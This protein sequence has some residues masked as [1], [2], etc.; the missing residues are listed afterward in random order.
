MK[1]FT[2]GFLTCFVLVAVCVVVFLVVAGVFAAKGLRRWR[3]A[4]KNTTWCDIPNEYTEMGVHAKKRE[5]NFGPK[6]GLVCPD[7]R[8]SSL[9]EKLRYALDATERVVVAASGFH[10]VSFPPGAWN[11]KVYG[12]DND[13]CVAASFETP[14]AHWLVFRG[15]QTTYDLFGVDA[16][17]PQTS[18]MLGDA[19]VGIHEGFW[20]L[21]QRLGIDIPDSNK[22]VACTGH[23]MGAALCLVAA[24]EMSARLPQPVHSF[25]F[26]C[27]RVGDCAFIDVAEKLCAEVVV[28]NNSLDI[29]PAMPLPVFPDPSKPDDP[30]A[31]LVYCNPRKMLTF[32]L[33]RNSIELNH[34]LPVYAAGLAELGL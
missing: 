10:D 13:Q 31:L 27:P 26:A 3:W 4:L 30:K 33:Q 11:G 23:S 34:S 1:R 32:T 15:T 25:S 7:L 9:S 19:K 16:K 21:Y 6:A 20:S 22:P 2:A 8:T 12:V 28:V 17:V 29:V 14:H 5:C 24:T 18:V